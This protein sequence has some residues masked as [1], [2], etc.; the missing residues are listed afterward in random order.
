[1]PE[2]YDVPVAGGSL[3]VTSWA[4]SGPPVLAIHGI[5]SSS[6]SW[7]FLAQALGRTVLAP[8]LRG[9]GRSS[10]LPGPVGMAAHAEDCAAVLRAIADEP[11]VVV[12]HSM[13]G[14]VAGV[15]AAR[16]PDLVRALVLVDGGLPFPP[17]D[18]QATLAGLAPITQRLQA[19]Y[20]REEY[21][22]WFRRHPAFARDWTPEA[23]EY[24]DYDLPTEP[25]RPSADPEAVAADQVDMVSG[26]TFAEAITRQTH[27][28][29]FLHAGRGFADDPP[30]LYPQ[31]TVDAYSARWPDLDVRRVA[32]VNHYTIVL[33]RRGAAAVAA[34]V[35]DLVP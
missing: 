28:R 10:G 16:H 12:G 21:R 1:M 26:T 23:E 24:A 11:L 13:G 22:D 5:T 33:S 34:A 4:G 9:R 17:A 25:G 18:E 27:P 3:R 29:V 20:T 32:D 15:L 19:S 35:T 14:F 8:D 6:R 7:P 2:A 31:A 30:G